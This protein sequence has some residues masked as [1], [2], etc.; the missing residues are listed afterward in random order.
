MSGLSDTL[1]VGLVL[2]LLFGSIA[3]YLYT[4]IQQNE[5]KISL[6]ESILLDLKMSGE[7][8]GYTESPA[9]EAKEIA[10]IAPVVAEYAPFTSYETDNFEEKGSSDEEDR[11][12]IDDSEIR[13]GGVG[14]H[15]STDNEEISYAS[16]IDSA[17]KDMDDTST[18]PG[19][20]KVSISYESMTLQELKQI[21]K[22]KGI[23]GVSSMKKNQILEALKT[24][25]RATGE[26]ESGTFGSNDITS[27]LDS[28]SP[29][30]GSLTVDA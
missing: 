2:V 1:T 27:F 13:S 24:V 21:A 5:Q 12:S 8:K 9:L 7:V 15:K 20:S 10:H 16:V 14:A 22:D 26:I 19:A 28:S 11:F 23:S 17:L 3:L 4:R 30:D 6:L 25:S 18:I 29:I